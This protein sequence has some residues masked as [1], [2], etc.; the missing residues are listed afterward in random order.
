MSRALMRK[1]AHEQWAATALFAVGLAAVEALLAYV[2]PT[3]FS[4]YSAQFLQIEFVRNVIKGL[5]GTE[6]GDSLGPT[7]MSAFAWVHP[8]VL[9]L[10][11]AHVIAFCTTM[12]A[13]EVER[14]T[15]DVFFSLPV[16]RFRHYACH[17]A[18]WLGAGVA[19]VLA[20]F[21]GN[22]IGAWLGGNAGAISFG[23]LLVVC[24]NMFC[25]YVA[26]GGITYLVS[27][28][29]DRRGRAVGVVFAIVL[30][31]FFLNFLAQ[32]WTPAK[33]FAPLSLLHYYRPI[34]IA[35]DAVWPGM[36]MLV[37]LLVGSTLWIAGAFVFIR[38]DLRTA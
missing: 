18:V 16:S 11:W 5:I 31:S 22:R 36:D 23:R 6:L 19:L 10:F 27:T 30:A 33:P 7:A 32:L 17:S 28:L 15:I 38:R 13:G 8:I 25:L 37:L 29:S 4:Q 34:P 1:T 2:I 26:V 20:A 12:P 14:G 24:G 35:R 3:L 21:V 9:A